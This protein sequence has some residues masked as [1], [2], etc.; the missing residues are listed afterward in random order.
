MEQ[1]W[2]SLLDGSSSL[3]GGSHRLHVATAARL[4]VLGLLG[5]KVSKDFVHCLFLEVDSLSLAAYGTGLLGNVSFDGGGGSLGDGSLGRHGG[6]KKIEKRKRELCGY[7]ESFVIL[8]LA[9]KDFF[10]PR[11]NAPENWAL[12]FVLRLYFP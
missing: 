3:P 11:K 4:L 5:A 6:G 9:E 8:F 2:T 7:C 12:L 10:S 1:T